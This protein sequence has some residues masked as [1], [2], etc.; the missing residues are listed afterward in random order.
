MK[1]RIII[2]EEEIESIYQAGPPFSQKSILSTLHK[3]FWDYAELS[4]RFGASTVVSL[5]HT[6]AAD[7]LIDNNIEEMTKDDLKRSHE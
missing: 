7:I 5:A 2:L 4:K 3:L 1:T 6:L